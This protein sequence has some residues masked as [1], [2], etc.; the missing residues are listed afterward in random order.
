MDYHFNMKENMKEN[1]ITLEHVK[2]AAEYVFKSFDDRSKQRVIK[3]YSY[4]RGI[5]GPK[6]YGTDATMDLCDHP[7][8]NNCRNLKSI[9]KEEV[10]KLIKNNNK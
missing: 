10:E 4:C 1:M 6:N 3:F 7:E 9:F 8:C 2:K 5:D